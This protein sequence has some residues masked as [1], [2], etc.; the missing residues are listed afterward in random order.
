MPVGFLPEDRRRQ[1]GRF[2]EDPTE[3]Q[4]A[5][6]CHLDDADRARLGERQVDHNRLGFAVQ[7]CTVRFLGTFLADPQVVPESIVAYVAAQLAIDDPACFADYRHPQ[8]QQRHAREIREAHGYHQFNDQPYHFTLTRWLL[9]RAWL[10]GERPIALFD[11]AAGWLIEHKVLLPG[12]SV[13]ERL[14]ARVRSRANSRLWRLLA[15]APDADQKARLK[16]LLVTDDTG[17]SKL[18][19]LRRA[20][21]RLSSPELV[22]AL[23]RLTEIRALGAGALNLNRIPA[24]RIRMLA[25]YAAEARAQAIARMPEERQIATLVAFAKEY[26]VLAQDDALDLF[27]LLLAKL[28]GE[29]REEGQRERLK[30]LGDLDE[31]AMTLARACQML[32]GEGDETTDIR[33]AIFDL[34]PRDELLRALETVGALSR[35]QDDLYYDQLV[36]RYA[37]VRRFLPTFLETL[38]FQSVDTARGVIRALDFLASIEDKRAPDMGQA[39]LGIVTGRWRLLVIGPDGQVDRKAYTFCVLDQLRAHLRRR[40]VF[41]S[42]SY[43]WIDPRARL[44]GGEQWESLRPS[45]CRDLN[46]PLS[47]EEALVELS[48]A[49]DQAYKDAAGHLPGNAAVRIEGALGH[50]RVVLTPL[51]KLEEP[52]SLAE[53][54]A[55]V[56]ALMPEVELPEMLLEVNRWTNFTSEFTHLGEDSAWIEDLPISICAV[57]M[58][59]ACNIGLKPV[60][61]PS[62]PALKLDR[63]RWVQRHYVRA[64]TIT[65]ANARLVDA[66]TTIPLAEVWGGGEVAS[67]DGL[68]FVVPVKTLSAGPNPKYFGRQRG[69]T[70]L[71]YVS[72]QYTGFHSIVV[73]GTLR[74]SLYVLDGM[75]EHQT[76]LSPTELMSDTAGY[77]DIVFGLFWLLGFQFS[78]RLADLGDLRFWR[79]DVAADYGA[80]SA[81]ARHPLKLGRIREH[82]DDLLRIAGSL[83]QGE[84]RASELIRALTPGGNTSTLA[85]AI[86]DVGRIVKTLYLLSY[87]DD[88][89]YR[90]RILNQLTRG[91]RRHGVARAVFFGKKGELRKAYR[92][93]QE[94]QLG[95]LGLVVNVLVLW[96][97]RYTDHALS[98]LRAQGAVGEEDIAR[99]SPLISEHINLLGQYRF[100]LSEQLSAGGYR[101]LREPDTPG[102]RRGGS[103]L[104]NGGAPL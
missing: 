2:C 61:R 32:L 56:A 90:R 22:R 98:R 45:I 85:K 87:I 27:D 46:L 21:R 36:E 84:V 81:V 65:A 72:D 83:R 102:G 71:G 103:S 92:E 5:H 40:D 3:A 57:L 35:P 89:A 69:V 24:R 58:A 77:S 47:A 13:L 53:L 7:L 14:V 67:V 50:E 62:V 91:E 38:C 1:H 100:A 9:A 12:A 49:L 78:P 39:P 101:P 37:T 18:D 88:D 75:L 30:T 73:T 80:L 54:R 52:P 33:E 64:D 68:R 43:R 63:L 44:L 79:I 15:A 95:A 86:G 97:T 59:E 76:S 96:N 34:V 51:E 93:G 6:F 23:D 10:G 8:V 82:W 104:A 29:A 26:E 31:A 60:S 55:R 42:P 28:L 74:D 4:L 66:Q 41:V 20:P 70:L 99:L 16:R 48:A 11:G 17:Q 94:D 19:V 25:R